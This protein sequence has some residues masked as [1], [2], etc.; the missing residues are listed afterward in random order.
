[1]IDRSIKEKV[2]MQANLEMEDKGDM[3]L[4]MQKEKQNKMVLTLKYR[5]P[6][7]KTVIRP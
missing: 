3:Q 4:N 6:E 2:D 7:V 5:M 1:M